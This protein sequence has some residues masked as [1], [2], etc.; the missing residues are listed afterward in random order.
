MLSYGD[1]EGCLKEKSDL[2]MKKNSFCFTVK[3]TCDVD[4]HSSKKK[5]KSNKGVLVFES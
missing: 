3:L 2:K 1:E 5:K 4:E